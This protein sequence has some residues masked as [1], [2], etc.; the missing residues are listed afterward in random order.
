MAIDLQQT[1]ILPARRPIPGSS[2]RPS[3][4]VF[5][6]KAAALDGRHG[7]PAGLVADANGMI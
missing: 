7:R 4:H 2:D 1:A 6:R 5:V 3:F